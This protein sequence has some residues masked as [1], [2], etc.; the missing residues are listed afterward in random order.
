MRRMKY[1]PKCGS[2]NVNSPVFYRPS[3][4]KC[5]DCGYEGAFIIEGSIF[6]EKMQERYLKRCNI[7]DW[8]EEEY[9]MDNW[10]DSTDT[11]Q[12]T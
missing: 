1:C 10:D 4:W 12:K 9:R 5:S 8:M 7:I 3:I 6:A 2:A 11:H